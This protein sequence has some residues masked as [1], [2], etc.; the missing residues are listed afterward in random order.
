VTK[1]ANNIKITQPKKSPQL[2]TQHII[3][4]NLGL[5]TGQTEPGLV[6]FYDI[7]PGKRVGLFLEPWSLHWAV[8]MVYFL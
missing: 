1:H 2:T 7:R 3:I 6:A 4:R 5:E 8:D